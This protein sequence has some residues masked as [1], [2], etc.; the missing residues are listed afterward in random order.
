M[1]AQAVKLQFDHYKVTKLIHKTNLSKCLQS[2]IQCPPE[3][4]HW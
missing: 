4:G 1:S 3:H 2:F